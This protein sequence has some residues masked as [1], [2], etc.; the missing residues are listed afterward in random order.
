[1]RHLMSGERGMNQMEL[2]LLFELTD[3]K[4]TY[5]YYPENESEK[6]GIVSVDRRTFKRT[7]DKLCE[8]YGDEYAFH[9]LGT[10]Q[11]FVE[12]NDFKTKKLIAWY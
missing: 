6:Y 3:E 2:I 7:I 5:K 9:A 11:N 10:I 12:K 4:V 1:M 8:G